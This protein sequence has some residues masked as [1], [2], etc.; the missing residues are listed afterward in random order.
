MLPLVGSSEGKEGGPER[1]EGEE[2]PIKK[3]QHAEVTPTVPSIAEANYVWVQCDLCNKWR[4]LPKG[5]VVSHHIVYH[6]QHR[7]S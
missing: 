1:L 3:S 6:I 2:L 7:W 4:E 5:H